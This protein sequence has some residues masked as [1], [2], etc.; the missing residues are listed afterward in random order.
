MAKSREELR[1]AALAYLADHQVMTLAT[2]GERGPWAAAVFYA[3]KGFHL[4]FLSADHTRHIE[5]L[6]T[7]G[8]CAAAIQEDYRDWPEIKGIQLEGKVEQLSGAQQNQAIALYKA[9]FPFL[10]AA[11]AQIQTALKK[12]SWFRLAPDYLFFIDNSQ[13]LGHRDLI[14]IAGEMSDADEAASQEN[15]RADS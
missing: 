13:G 1:Q 3:S 8:R 7:D 10:M 2:A 12:V 6:M 5:D 14:H 11:G 9:K 15:S 4:Y